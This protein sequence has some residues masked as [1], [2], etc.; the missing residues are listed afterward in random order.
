MLAVERLRSWR[1]LLVYPLF[2]LVLP[3]CIITSEL[4]DYPEYWEPQEETST[5]EKCPALAGLYEERGEAPFGCLETMEACHS[6]SYNL[7]SGNIGYKEVWDESSEPRLPTGTHVELRQPA[8]NRLEVIQWQ[9]RDRKAHFLRKETL[10]LEKGDFT[11]GPEGLTLKPRL[12]Y[13]L[14]VIGNLLGAVSTNFERNEDGYLVME[15]RASIVG[16]NVFILGARRFGIWVRWTP[17][18]W[19][20]AAT[21]TTIH[22]GESRY[23]EIA[24]LPYEQLLTKAEMGD[25]EA[26]LQLYWLPNE[27]ERLTW[28]CRAADQGH[29]DAQYRLGLLHRYGNEGVRQDTVRAYM[30]YRLAASKGHHSALADAQVPLETLTAG[31]AMEAEILLQK[32]EPGQCALEVVPDNPSK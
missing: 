19:E 4:P 26:Q 23:G 14:I 10:K 13:Y 21:S 30:W 6:L 16:H 29:P 7:L 2:V 3:S 25:A 27:P 17:T 31:Q 12:F 22:T 5:T 15:S 8:D 18:T 11:C 28:L 1:A 9:W 20:E 24:G 32:W